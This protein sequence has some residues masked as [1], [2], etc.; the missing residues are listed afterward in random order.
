MKNGVR[1]GLIETGAKTK[2]YGWLQGR[3]ILEG[4]IKA[5]ALSQEGAGCV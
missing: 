1:A 2:G 3:N 4:T 5:S